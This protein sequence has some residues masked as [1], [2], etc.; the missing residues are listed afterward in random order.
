MWRSDWQRVFFPS[1]FLVHLPIDGLVDPQQDFHISLNRVSSLDP[2]L[3][4]N[5]KHFFGSSFTGVAK[6]SASFFFSH[7]KEVRWVQTPCFCPGYNNEPWQVDSELKVTVDKEHLYPFVLGIGWDL[8][9]LNRGNSGLANIFKPSC[10][11]LH[12]LQSLRKYEIMFS[13]QN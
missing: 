4:A 2:S 10:R 8:T 3:G 13:Q 9:C 11:V 5:L 6:N 12:G 1:L 7:K